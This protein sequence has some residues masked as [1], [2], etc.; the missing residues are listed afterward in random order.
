[1]IAHLTHEFRSD[2]P[3]QTRQIAAALAQ[4]LRAG[5][6][7][8]LEGELG[9]GKTCFVRGLAEGLGLDSKQVASPTFVL[10]HEYEP[11]DASR[12]ATTLIHSDAYRLHSTNELEA[13]GWQELLERGDAIIALEWPSRVAGGLPADRIDVRIQHTGE[14]SRIVSISVPS[15]LA[16]RLR[17]L[18]LPTS[19]ANAP[20]QS[21][22]QTI[23][24]RTCGR[25]YDRSAKTFPFCSDRCR[26][27]DL[28]QWFREGYRTS[29]A[30][31]QDD[32]LSE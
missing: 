25:L 5:D 15:A 2:S 8:A 28:G 4:G 12:G 26:M 24:C 19:D 21:P 30:V 14:T 22:T 6:V 9:A 10:S 32:E 17:H 27:A 29:R 3:E 11:S 18:H 16:D 31:E 7:V 20:A 23:A 1:M 13:V